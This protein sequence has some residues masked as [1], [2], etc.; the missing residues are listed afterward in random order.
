MAIISFATL[1]P[2]VASAGGTMF[3]CGPAGTPGANGQQGPQGVQ[4]NPGPS[5]T[6]TVN[7]IPGPNITL[8]AGN[9]GAVPTTAAGAA[10]DVATLDSTGHVPLAELPAA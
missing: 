6:L 10:N 2:N 7:G 9:V 4:G 8:N 5:L 3:P 1:A